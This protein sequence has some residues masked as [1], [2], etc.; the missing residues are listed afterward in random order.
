MMLLQS[1]QQMSMNGI[2]SSLGQL[3]QMP[4]I[5]PM[6]PQIMMPASTS[7][8]L[9]MLPGSAHSQQYNQNNQPPNVMQ[10]KP[11]YSNF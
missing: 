1:Q 10:A 6:Q 9:G 5:M 11:I 2:G 8:N 7:S 3:P 4:Q